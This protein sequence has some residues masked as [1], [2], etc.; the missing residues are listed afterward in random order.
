[1][2]LITDNYTISAFKH[3]STLLKGIQSLNVVPGAQ[4]MIGRGSGAVDPS[5]VGIGQILNEINFDTLAIKTALAGLGGISGA[6]ISNDTFY[7]QKMLGDGLRGGALSHI[8]CVAALGL[9]VPVRIRAAQGQP[10]V[11]SYRA[12][13]RSADGVTSPF[14]MTAGQSL[15]A[16][17]DAI[18]EVYTLGPVTINGVALEMV[19]NIDIDFGMEVWTNILDGHIYVTACGV[20]R[21]SPNIT[22]TTLDMAKFASWGLPGQAQGETDS[23]IQLLDQAAGGVR[24]S[25]PITFSI[26]SGI[27]HFDSVPGSDGQAIA[28]Q[29]VITPVYD[30]LNA[31]LAITG[32]T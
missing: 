29:A 16:A 17:Q 21:R 18:T 5:F 19:S 4:L 10:A 9:I 22:I 28:G 23:T 25:A 1:M 11:L 26:D 30:G 31:I 24:G 32:I 12:I 14:A 13:P 3:S 8:K 15:E 20:T 7:F 27:I 2:T 6:A